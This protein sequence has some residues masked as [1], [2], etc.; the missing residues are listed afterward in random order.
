MQ[1]ILATK[2]EEAF[3]PAEIA[4]SYASHGAACLSVLT[5]RPFFQGAPEYLQAGRCACT[6]PV[7]RKDFLIDPYQVYESRVMGADCVLLI[8]SALDNGLMAELEALALDLAMAVL[9]ECHDAA[10]LERGLRLSTPLIG[11][12]SRDLRTF[13]VNLEVALDLLS[14]IPKDRVGVMESGIATAREVARVRS[15]GAHALLVGEAFMRASDPGQALTQL[16]GGES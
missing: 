14:S 12:N 16:L 1:R 7:M 13:E 15:L 10:E 5:D 6:L 3:D 11:I 2:R 8:V 4:R 9:V